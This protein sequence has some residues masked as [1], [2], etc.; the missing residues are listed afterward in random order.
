MYASCTEDVLQ[1]LCLARNHLF[2][3]FVALRDDSLPPSSLSQP[4]PIWNQLT[5][6][7]RRSRAQRDR[8]GG[9]DDNY[10]DDDRFER[11]WA[12]K[13]RRTAPAVA[14]TATAPPTAS[15]ASTTAGPADAATVPAKD[16]GGDAADRAERMRLKKRL[17]KERKR[18]KKASAAAEQGARREAERRRREVADRIREEKDALAAAKRK[19]EKKAGGEPGGGRGLGQG[20]TSLRKGVRC[21]DLVVGRGPTARDRKKVRVSYLLRARSHTTG[22]LLDSSGNFG[23]RLGKG[24]VIEGWDIGVAGMRVGGTRRLIVPREAGYGNKDVGAGRGADLY[25]EIELLQVAA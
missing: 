16:G 1:K 19:V 9:D 18:E 11:E 5:D 6:M 21:L 7:G 17:R 14:A 8:S 24:E 22:K 20:F 3:D 12:L 2:L 10:E 13:R 15:D 4:F 23:F 25:F